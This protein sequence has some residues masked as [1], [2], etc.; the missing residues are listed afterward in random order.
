MA[1]VAL[2][3]GSSRGIGRAIACCLADVGYDI[4]VNYE[5]NLDAAKQT[6]D[7]V[8][9]R[10]RRPRI[11]G[12]SVAVPDESRRLIEFTMDAFGRIDL[13]V[14]NAGI[15]PRTRRDIL[16]T[17]PESYDEV[18]DTNLKGPY[19]LTQLAATHMIQLT[20]NGIIPKARIVNITSIS[21]FASSTSR[22]EYCISK[23]GLSMMT[24]LF[25]ARL[26]EHGITV[27]EIQ[28]GVIKTDMTGPVREIYDRRIAEGLTPI[29]RWGQPEDVGKAV[30]AVA[31]GYF[32]F[33][34][35]AAIPVDGG[36]HLRRL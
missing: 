19:F 33:T 22:G 29:R 30:A 15:A 18:L 3:T 17:P 14:N 5:K 20:G 9:K 7:E 12:A 35:G 26:A 1:P 21:A 2:V 36:F 6:A 10:N 16:E 23:A 25:A 11:C 28:P 32:D 4:V 24:M 8:R 31:L 13:L 34:T 27:N